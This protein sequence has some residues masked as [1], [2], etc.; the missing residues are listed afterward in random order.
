MSEYKDIKENKLVI[1][2]GL[3]I[4]AGL[5]IMNMSLQNSVHLSYS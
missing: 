5:Y 1:D 3:V 4:K 2:M